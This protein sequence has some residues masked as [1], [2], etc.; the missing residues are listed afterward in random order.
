VMARRVV[1]SK[2]AKGDNAR[3]PVSVKCSKGP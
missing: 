2:R 1:E 3:N